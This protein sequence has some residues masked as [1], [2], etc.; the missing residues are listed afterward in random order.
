[1][2]TRFHIF[3]ITMQDKQGKQ[4]KYVHTMKGYCTILKYEPGHNSK[5][6]IVKLDDGT[7]TLPARDEIDVN[8]VS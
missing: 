6:H 8:F 1:M 3:Y 7:T 2:V 5:G 4:H